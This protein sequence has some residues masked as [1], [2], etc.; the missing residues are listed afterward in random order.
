MRLILRRSNITCGKGMTHRPAAIAEMCRRDQY[1]ERKVGQLSPRCAKQCLRCHRHVDACRAAPRVAPSAAGLDPP[2]PL[3]PR[4]MLG[5][6]FSAVTDALAPKALRTASPAWPPGIPPTM[7]EEQASQTRPPDHRWTPGHGSPDL[8]SSSSSGKNRSPVCYG[9][10]GQIDFLGA[11]QPS[12]TTTLCT[13]RLDAPSMPVGGSTRPARPPQ[14]G[15][16]S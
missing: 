14:R 16:S 6:P 13:G 4:L 11:G 12:S 7:T 1:R 15:A 9:W 10:G 5:H 2:S 3:N 8:L